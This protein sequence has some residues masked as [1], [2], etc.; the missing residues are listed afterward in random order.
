MVIFFGTVPFVG[1]GVGVS[2][3]YLYRERKLTLSA[4]FFFLCE[5]LQ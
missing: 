4:V 5:V 3:V 1:L 2:L